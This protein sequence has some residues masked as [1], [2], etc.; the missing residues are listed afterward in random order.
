M[1]R[2]GTLLL[3]LAAGLLLAAGAGDAL[4]RDAERR[5]T[6]VV[7]AVDPVAGTVTLDGTVFHV[8]THTVL[9][10]AQGQPIV[11]GD[12]RALSAG[13]GAPADAVLFEASRRGRSGRWVL[14]LLEVT[15]DEPA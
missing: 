13:L 3:G 4:A 7:E 6:E 12:L 10:G 14:D 1:R 2:R 15:E 8:G 11:L 9:R 5:G